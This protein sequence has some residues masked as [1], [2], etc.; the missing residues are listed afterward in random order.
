LVKRNFDKKYLLSEKHQSD[1]E[2]KGYTIYNDVVLKLELEELKD[3]FNEISMHP[4]FIVNGSFESSG[5]F[6]DKELQERIFS[7]LNKV[8]TEITKRIAKLENCE[9][10]DGGAF[11]IKPPGKK[12][13]LNPHQDSA[14]IDES[15]GY[16]IFVWI[17]LT[18]CNSSTGALSVLPGSHLFGNYIRAQHIPWSFRNHIE[19]LKQN[20]VEVPAVPGDL[21]CFDTSLIHG[22][23]INHSNEIRV[24][25]CGALLPKNHKKIEYKSEGKQLYKYEIQNEYWLDGGNPDNLLSYPKIEVENNFPN[26]ITKRQLK[27]LINDTHNKQSFL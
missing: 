18:D 7:I 12:G 20:M 6:L 5:N 19:V 25:A 4:K 16:G 1:F 15:E 8:T 17:P 14:V 2:I 11:F 21:I 22:S 23:G 10:G 24:A 3:G 9:P 26:P 13:I 27:S